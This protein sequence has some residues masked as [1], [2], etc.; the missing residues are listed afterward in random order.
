VAATRAAEEESVVVGWEEVEAKGRAAKDTAAA[1]KKGREETGVAG[2][3]HS[4]PAGTAGWVV[5]GVAKWA[6]A[7]LARAP[8]AMGKAAAG[9]TGREETDAAGVE[10][11]GPERRVDSAVAAA[12]LVANRLRHRAVE[13]AMVRAV[14]DTAAADSMGRGEPDAAGV[15]KWVAAGRAVGRAAE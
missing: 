4:G 14:M 1:G 9:E 8:A 7:D 12:A 15:A 13:E 3:E 5:A 2:A 11:S 6:V 10:H